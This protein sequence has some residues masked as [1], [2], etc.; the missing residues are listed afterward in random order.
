MRVLEVLPKT[1]LYALPLQGAL[2]CV[3][4]LVRNSVFDFGAWL[5]LASWLPGF[6][7]FCSGIVTTFTTRRIRWLG[8][9]V[10][11]FFVWCASVFFFA[12]VGL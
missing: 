10:A 1:G 8:L 4:F 12:G 9:S 2:V 11:A 5:A 7:A 6:V 3:A